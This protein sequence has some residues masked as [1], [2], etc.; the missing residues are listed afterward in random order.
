VSTTA[1]A[2]DSLATLAA[3][4]L[5]KRFGARTALQSVS[6]EVHS[7]EIVAV[8]GPNGA[9]KTTLLSI[10]A[11]IL[12]PD[13]GEVTIPAQR[14]GWVP[15]QPAIYSKLSVGENLRLFAAGEVG[16]L[17]SRR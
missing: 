10:L 16:R 9:G 8:I 7:G 2:G 12:E 4:A 1:P 14:L 6:F 11:G 15:Q 13:G 17:R 3:H 5:T